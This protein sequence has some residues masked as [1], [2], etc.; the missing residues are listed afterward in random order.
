M[1]PH[2]LKLFVSFAVINP[3]YMGAQVA[4]DR[5]VVHITS[6]DGSRRGAENLLPRTHR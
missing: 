3:A 1:M 4:N 2:I 6:K 5:H